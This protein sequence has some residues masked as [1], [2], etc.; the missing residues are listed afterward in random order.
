MGHGLGALLGLV[1][2]SVGLKVE[3]VGDDVGVVVGARVVGELEGGVGFLV[4]LV[5]LA[6]V[7]L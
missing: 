1:G 4:V 7:G 6:D 5:G 2:V 3:E